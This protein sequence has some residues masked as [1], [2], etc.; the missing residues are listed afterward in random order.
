MNEFHGDISRNIIQFLPL[1]KGAVVRIIPF[2]HQD[3]HLL[4]KQFVYLGRTRN[5]DNFIL[6]GECA[7]NSRVIFHLF[8]GS[9]KYIYENIV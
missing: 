4:S 6:R 9:Y 5:R 3:N 8:P 7:N 1:W 2:R